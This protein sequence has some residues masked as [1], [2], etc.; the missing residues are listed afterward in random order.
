M[1]PWCEPILRTALEINKQRSKEEIDQILNQYW[2]I[3]KL[4]IKENPHEYSSYLT[5]TY[6]VLKKI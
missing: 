6:L 1:R 5:Y 2:T 3:Y 4:K